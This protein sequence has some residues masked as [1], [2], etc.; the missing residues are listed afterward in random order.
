M[1]PLV[2]ALAT[3][4]VFVLG[5]IGFQQYMSA[6]GRPGSVIDSFYRM[7]TLFELD[8]YDVEPPIPWAMEVARFLAPALLGYAVFRG[9]MAVFRSQF[10][11]AGIRLLTRGHVVVAGLGE[12]GLRLAADFR[13]HGFRVIAIEIDE[14]D[15]HIQSAHQRG[16]IVLPGDARDPRMLSKARVDHA[17][18]LIAVCGEDGRNVEVAVS[19]AKLTAGRPAGVL[20][21]LVHLQEPGLWRMLKAEAI[22]RLGHRALRMEFFNVFETGARILLDERPPFSLAPEPDAPRRPHVLVVGLQGLGDALVLNV[23]RRWQNSQPAPGEELRLSILVGEAEQARTRLVAR[24]PELERIC[25]LRSISAPVGVELQRGTLD[26]D[27]TGGHPVSAVYICLAARSPGARGGAGAPGSCRS[28]GR[29][30]S[31]WP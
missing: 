26:V 10:Q 9:V 2:L 8:G 21:A 28:S 1:R 31:P 29:C 14:S 19:A 18:Y 17:R 3:I 15:G 4:A 30:R 27:Q 12:T 11:L 7:L 22:T 25:D 13:S 6:H 24:Y 23:A 20:H 5:T 16:I